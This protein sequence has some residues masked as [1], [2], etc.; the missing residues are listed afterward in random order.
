MRMN[1]NFWTRIHRMY[2][3][4]TIYHEGH[5]ETQSLSKIFFVFL[6]SFVVYWFICEICVNPRPIY[7]LGD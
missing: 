2:T 4:H 1:D 6:V 5:E 7:I 3:D